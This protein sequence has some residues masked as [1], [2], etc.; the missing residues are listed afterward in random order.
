MNKS[1]CDIISCAKDNK[2]FIYRGCAKESY[3]LVP[4]L[5]RKLKD[6]VNFN[7][8]KSYSSI[9]EK[10]AT[11][12]FGE[13]NMLGQCEDL[14]Q[15][16]GLPTRFLDWSHSVYTALYFAF[17]SYITEFVTSNLL[18]NT[19]GA[20]TS[21]KDGCKYCCKDGCKNDCKNDKGGDYLYDDF[22]N[23][24]YCLYIFDRSLYI[25][26]LKNEHIQSIPLKFSDTDKSNRR[27]FA[28]KGLL[29]YIDC[30]D[31]PGD[32][33]IITSQI[34]I[35]KH[36]LENECPSVVPKEGPLTYNG[37]NLLQKVIFKLNSSDRRLLIKEL[38]HNNATSL[39]LFPDFEGVKKNIE[40]SEYYNLLIDYDI[41]GNNNT[42]F[43]DRFCP[44]SSSFRPDNLEHSEFFYYKK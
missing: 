7:D 4:T 14:S 24:S 28:Q 11:K 6:N 29:S 37:N 18:S 16:Y 15:H 1:L 31:L 33:T 36:Y 26:F 40:L 9:I 23:H 20:E 3:D 32:D 5:A 17:T 35:L 39:E 42:P 2:G 30:E 8:F 34:D 38:K 22:N 41:A 19:N 44:A 43:H 21:K 27:M 13:V 25:D 10:A 12:G